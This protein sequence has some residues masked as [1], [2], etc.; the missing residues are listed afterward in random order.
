MTEEHAENAIRL[1][2]IV[3]D[4]YGNDKQYPYENLPFLVKSDG[5]VVLSDGL[6]AELSKDENS[7]LMD[8]AHENIVGLFE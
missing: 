3:H 1:L 5:G 6:M 4:L 8:W 2:D 7:D